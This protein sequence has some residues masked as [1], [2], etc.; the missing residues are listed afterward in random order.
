MK[1]SAQS[2]GHSGVRGLSSLTRAAGPLALALCLGTAC[3]DNK[4]PPEVMPVDGCEPEGLPTDALAVPVA[5]SF[6][7]IVDG[8]HWVYAHKGG[9]TDWQ[10]EVDMEAVQGEAGKFLIRD[11][12]SP[13]GSRS[14]SELSAVGTRIYRVFKKSFMGDQAAGTVAY[15][16]GFARFDVTWP[17]LAPGCAEALMYGRKERDAADALVRDGDREHRFEVEQTEVTVEVDAGKFTDCI[18]IYRTKIR[19]AGSTAGEEDNKRYWFCAGVGKVKEEEETTN[20]TEELVS[21][22]IPG[23]QCP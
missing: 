3:G 5:E 17:L 6:Y 18:V 23:G 19:S 15:D 22:E 9:S 14:E 7:P 2:A 16:P 12:P 4:A 8:A 21:C 1:R 10:E 11:T 13:S 20:K